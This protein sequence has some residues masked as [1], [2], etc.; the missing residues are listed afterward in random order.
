MYGG[1]SIIPMDYSSVSSF[2]FFNYWVGWGR[3]V[4]KKRGGGRKYS[5]IERRRCNNFVF[6]EEAIEVAWI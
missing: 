3:G 4:E 6:E 5:I 2:F 1:D